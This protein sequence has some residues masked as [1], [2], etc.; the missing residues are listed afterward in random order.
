M[1]RRAEFRREDLREEGTERRKRTE[2]EGGMERAET[3]V[4]VVAWVREREVARVSREW[5]QRTFS[6]TWGS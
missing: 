3:R 6:R 5:W 1:R 4:L 2:M